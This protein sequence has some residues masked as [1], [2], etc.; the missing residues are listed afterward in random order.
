MWM[1]LLSRLYR[2]ISRQLKV[3]IS[4]LEHHLFNISI[5]AIWYEMRAR[6]RRKGRSARAIGTVTMSSLLNLLFNG[7]KASSGKYQRRRHTRACFPRWYSDTRT[8]KK[9]VVLELLVRWRS[10]LIGRRKQWHVIL[11]IVSVLFGI[12]VRPLP[13]SCYMTLK[14]WLQNLISRLFSACTAPNNAD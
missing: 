11:S 10:L 14:I 5:F 7:L 1:V 4:C 13:S 9:S 2:F 12:R 3:Y 8:P 6:K